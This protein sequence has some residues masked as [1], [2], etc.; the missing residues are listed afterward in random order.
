MAMTKQFTP[1]GTQTRVAAAKRLRWL[2]GVPRK[3]GRIPATVILPARLFLAV[4]YLYAGLQKFTDQQFF[5]PTAPGFVGAQMRGYVQVG[6]PLSPLLTRLAIPHAAFVGGG[7]AF[8]E[9][10]VG[11]SALTGL[12]TRARPA[13]RARRRAP[14]ATCDPPPPGV[15]PLPITGGVVG[16][17]RRYAARCRPARIRHGGAPTHRR[18]HPRGYRDI[19]RR[20][21]HNGG[22]GQHRD[23]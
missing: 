4:T 12:L 13:R 11:L 23:A 5:D 7:I 6:S 9:L 19:A 2:V 22:A 16:P 20:A 14:A 18:R 8:C 10:L 15:T 1:D 3:S 21:C 17:A